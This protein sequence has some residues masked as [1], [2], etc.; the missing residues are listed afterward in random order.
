MQKV[1]RIV[2]N[3][4]CWPI[5]MDGVCDIGDSLGIE[6][7][8][9]ICNAQNITQENIGTDYVK[10]KEINSKIT[11]NQTDMKIQYSFKKDSINVL[12]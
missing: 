6:K 9:G 4:L 3:I 8:G 5:K 2:G 11:M 12:K 1:P 7:L 10:I